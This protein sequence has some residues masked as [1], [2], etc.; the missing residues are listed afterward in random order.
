MKEH[1]KVGSRFDTSLDE[2]IFSDE[3]GKYELSLV[4]VNSNEK[5]RLERILN[6]FVASTS[7]VLNF[8]IDATDDK[9]IKLV[10]NIPEAV[11]F[12]KRQKAISVELY[13]DI[14]ANDKLN[15]F[16]SQSETYVMNKVNKEELAA[17]FDNED[18]KQ[19]NDVSDKRVVAQASQGGVFGKPGKSSSADDISSL[20]TLIQ[21]SSPTKSVKVK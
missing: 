13:S 1:M 19:K 12:L 9:A 20:S 7:K 16:I 5:I 6:A 2:L 18:E 15:D 10:G 17:L 14:R 21:P 8:D 11:E 4:F 3:E